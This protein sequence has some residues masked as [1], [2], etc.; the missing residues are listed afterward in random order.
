MSGFGGCL[1]ESKSR[2]AQQGSSV[3]RNQKDQSIGGQRPRCKWFGGQCE[4][5]IE[6]LKKVLDGLS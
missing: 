5:R 1:T 6:L 2:N 3:L 4:N